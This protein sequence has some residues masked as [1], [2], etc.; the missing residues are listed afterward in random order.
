M[1]ITVGSFLMFLAIVQLILAAVGVP[2]FTRWQWFP[3]GMAFW[4]ISLFM[5][6]T[7]R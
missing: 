5:S 6:V 3:G 2:G 7:V 4:A 1:T